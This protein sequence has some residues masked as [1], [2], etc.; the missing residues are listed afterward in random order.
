MN[1]N[2]LNIDKL[3]EIL[4]CYIGNL[5]DIE[6]NDSFYFKKDSENSYI[7]HCSA[8][9]DLPSIEFKKKKI[10]IEV[11]YTNDIKRIISLSI[12][13]S[14]KEKSDSNVYVDFNEPG[15]Y[16]TIENDMLFK[17]LRIFPY[18]YLDANQYCFGIGFDPILKSDILGANIP[19]TDKK[20]PR[21]NEAIKAF[22]GDSIEFSFGGKSFQLEISEEINWVDL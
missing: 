3:P 8:T 10:D 17:G 12:K 19:K 2:L 9:P 15:V 6:M 13:N 4:E 16:L 5:E 20:I 14:L 22:I 7:I 21:L 11:L 1:I 18:L